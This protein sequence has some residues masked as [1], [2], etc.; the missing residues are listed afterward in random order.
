M[1]KACM[2]SPE[3]LCAKDVVSYPSQWWAS[4]PH[5]NCFRTKFC[6][7]NVSFTL[8]P[9][10]IALLSSETRNY[11]TFGA[12]LKPELLH[13]NRKNRKLK[14]NEI[15]FQ[16]V[17]QR[18]DAEGGV[19]SGSLGD[20]GCECVFHQVMFDL[21]K[22]LKSLFGPAAP[23]GHRSAVRCQNVALFTVFSRSSASADHVTFRGMKRLHV[24]SFYKPRRFISSP[25]TI[26]SFL[27][28]HSTVCWTCWSQEFEYRRLAADVHI[29]AFFI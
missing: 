24:W 9:P 27:R 12:A 8:F 28:F 26:T 15:R 13:S 2:F 6:E 18:P 3:N 25:S 20:S 16:P 29:R 7:D 4:H 19:I 10:L 21:L 11:Q 22:T 14:G 23:G 17:T 5:E 1:L